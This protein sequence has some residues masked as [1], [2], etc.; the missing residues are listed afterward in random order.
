MGNKGLSVKRGIFF[1][2]GYSVAYTGRVGVKGRYVFTGGLI[3]ISRSRR[4]NR[5]KI[6]KALVSGPIIV[7]SEI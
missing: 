6:A 2:R 5:D 4:I 3:V 1:G 7:R